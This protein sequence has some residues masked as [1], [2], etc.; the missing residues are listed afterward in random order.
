MKRLV[1]IALVLAIHQSSALVEPARSQSGMSNDWREIIQHMSIVFLPDGQGGHVKTIRFTGVNVQVVNGMGATATM[2]GVGNLVVGYKELGNPDGDDRR[3]SHNIVGG[4]ENTH[5]SWGGFRLHRK[6]AVFGDLG[7]RRRFHS[8]VLFC[9][10]IEF[11]AMIKNDPK[12]TAI[13][14]EKAG[15]R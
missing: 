2:N 10:K 5:T 15:S 13:M 1:L 9:S 7:D 14:D 8:F 4:Q 6:A 3:G 11:F 12:Y